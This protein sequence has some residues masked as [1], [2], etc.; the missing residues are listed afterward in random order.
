MVLLVGKQHVEAG[1]RAVARRDVALQPDLLVLRQRHAIDLLLQGAKAIADHDNLVEEGLDRPALLLQRR[2]GRLQIAAHASDVELL[3]LDEPT[4]GLDPL[5]EAMFRECITEE[6][7]DG[8]TVLLSSHILAE[9]EA[10]CDRVSS[11]RECR[12]V[13]TGSLEEMRHLRRVSIT[14]DMA[15]SPDGL[16]ATPGVHD[17]RVDGTRV[18]CEVDAASLNAVLAKL[19][20]IGV[21]SLTSQLP[22]LEDLFLRH[23]ADDPS[24][25]RRE[26]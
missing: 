26:G 22:T 15:G 5:M 10:L 6:R 20:T 3:L 7:G 9:V 21:T 13:E 17:L 19:T 2:V 11:I 23:Y 16:G 4:S 1:Q 24:A 18:R 8:R 12:T 25:A 14:A